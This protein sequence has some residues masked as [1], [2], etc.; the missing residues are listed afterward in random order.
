MAVVPIARHRCVYDDSQTLFDANH[1]ISADKALL[2]AHVQRSGAWYW[3]QGRGGMV[4]VLYG[5]RE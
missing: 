5:E 1:H 3:Q 4:R 2:V